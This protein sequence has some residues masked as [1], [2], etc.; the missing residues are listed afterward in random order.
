MV[1]LNELIKLIIP[2]AEIESKTQINDHIIQDLAFFTFSSSHQAIRY[3]IQDS[4]KAKTATT[5]TYL[6]NNITNSHQE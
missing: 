1:I 5:A 2:Q 3:I 4:I 6:I